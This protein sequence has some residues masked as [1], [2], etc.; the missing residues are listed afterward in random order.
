MGGG[1]KIDVMA[2]LVLELDHDGGELG[3]AE[4]W[5]I[6]FKEM[7]DFVVLTEDAAQVAG[8]KKD[9]AGAVAAHQGTLLAEMGAV[10]RDRS[11]SPNAA[12]SK[13]F[14]DA[15][16]PAVERADGTMFHYCPGR[17]NTSLQFA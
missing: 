11:K 12:D 2:A 5:R 7:A 4:M 9:G 3:G 15:V 14:G 17:L 6:R 16:Y 10:A 13:S 8:G 1:D